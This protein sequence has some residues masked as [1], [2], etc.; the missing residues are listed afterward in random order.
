[1]E[2]KKQRLFYSAVSGYLTSA[3]F[4]KAPRAKI[5]FESNYV[6]ELD[7]FMVT[8]KTRVVDTFFVVTYQ[9]LRLRIITIS[10][11]WI[12]KKRRRSLQFPESIDKSRKCRNCN[13]QGYNICLMLMNVTD[14]YV[15]KVETRR[16]CLLLHLRPS[17]DRNSYRC[18][19]LTQLQTSPPLRS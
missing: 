4:I 3:V 15:I 6:G 10:C 11:N 19:S 18:V 9:N 7:F 5:S 14:V 1:M 2:Y 13:Y 16:L 12:S 17:F 8:V